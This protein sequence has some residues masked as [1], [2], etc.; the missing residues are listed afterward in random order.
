MRRRTARALGNGGDDHRPTAKDRVAHRIHVGQAEREWL[1]LCGR[2]RAQLNAEVESHAVAAGGK[3]RHAIDSDRTVGASQ[4]N[5]HAIERDHRASATCHVREWAWEL[6]DERD[7]LSELQPGTRPGDFAAAAQQRECAPEGE[8]RREVQP[9]PY[10][11]ES[12][13]GHRILTLAP[14][15]LARKGVDHTT[16]AVKPV[17]LPDA[18]Q[19][20]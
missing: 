5:A 6:R 1:S 12:S 16:G 10:G 9:F 4:D 15:T 14:G 17:T 11:E 2:G 13:G 20:R 18:S 3:E 8:E 19:R 7:P